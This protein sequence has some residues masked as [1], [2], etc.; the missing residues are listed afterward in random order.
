MNLHQ[1]IGEMADPLHFGYFGGYWTKVPW[2]LFGLLMTGL[3]VSGAAIYSLRIARERERPIRLA[4]SAAGMW[5]GMG[6]WRWLSVL[7][8]AIGFALLPTL[9]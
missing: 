8:I 9:F 4:R 1:R 7:L 6:R 5:R 3:S 2:F